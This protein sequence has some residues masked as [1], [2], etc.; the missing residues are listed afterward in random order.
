MNQDKGKLA[1]FVELAAPGLKARLICSYAQ[2]AFE[3]GRSLAVHVPDERE[4]RELDETLWTFAQDAFIPHVRLEEAKEPLI[5]PVILFS[6]DPGDLE[7]DV[8]LLSVDGDLPDWFGRFAHVRDFAVLYDEAL[9]QASRRRYAACK[10]AGYRMSM[11]K[12]G[13]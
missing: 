8:L 4:A 2:R 5:E 12:P 10:A 9:R 3:G 1:E 7:A 6:G 13:T 11:V